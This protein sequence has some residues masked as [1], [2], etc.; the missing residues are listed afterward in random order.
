MVSLFDD[1]AALDRSK[2]GY[3]VAG[4]LVRV[5]YKGTRGSQDYK[6]AVSYDD[7]RGKD[8]TAFLHI[9]PKLDVP[10]LNF[11]LHSALQ[12]VPFRDIMCHVNLRA[13]EDGMD[14]VELSADEHSVLLVAAGR[15]L[16]SS[17]RIR[18]QPAT[19]S[20]T[21]AENVDAVNRTVVRPPEHAHEGESELRRSGRVRTVLWY[22]EGLNVM[23]YIC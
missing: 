12:S 6:R 14:T 17:P 18:R 1:Y 8:K 19:G 15:L 3:L 9:Y 5:T 21:L 13:T 16:S 2:S 10:E 22:D 23:S 11:S 7:D 4:N 20:S